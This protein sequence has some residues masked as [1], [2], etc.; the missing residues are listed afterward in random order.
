MA[1]YIDAGTR[2]SYASGAKSFITFCDVEGIP[3]FPVDP[4]WL[5]AWILTVTTYVSVP[6]LKVYLAGI[7]F[8]QG[9]TGLEWTISGNEQVR[10]IL[11]Y[12]KKRYGCKSS[13]SKLPITLSMVARMA[14]SLSGWP[15]LELMSHNHRLF[16][17]MSVLAV[18][19][20]M[21]GG[22]FLHSIRS[23]RPPLLSRDIRI[24]E[25]ESIRFVSISIKKPK[26][27]WWL[28]DEFA[29]CFS[30]ALF[31]LLDP[32]RLLTGYR[33][34]SVVSLL[35]FEPAFRM[36]GGSTASKKRFLDDT[37]S[38]LRSS[39]LYVAYVDRFGNAGSLVAAS[40]RAGGVRTAKDA[41][42]Q[43][44]IIMVLGRWSSMAW[45]RY[46][47]AS[48][49][50]IR[51]AVSA[52][53]QSVHSNNIPR[54]LQQ[55]VGFDFPLVEDLSDAAESIRSAVSHRRAPPLPFEAGSPNRRSVG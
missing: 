46:F 47:S 54:L 23:N 2:K 11:L 35:P 33:N 30:S 18:M 37:I 5:C 55:Q 19:G 49:S 36:E 1:N 28:S 15:N 29:R 38:L 6:S 50:D 8:E 13:L 34:L 20:F 43:D 3:P 22:E 7:R 10:R 16:I 48:V 40:W 17:T 42:V 41:G 51:D 25:H 52:M 31:P 26:A 9:L 32:V 45:M 21:R 27:R 39:N 53:W 14:E 12:V 44:S 4:V 24:I